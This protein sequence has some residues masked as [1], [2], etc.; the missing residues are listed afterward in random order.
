MILSLFVA[1]ALSPRGLTLPLPA[2]IPS[3]V[4]P[5]SQPLVAAAT[6]QDDDDDG[7]EVESDDEDEDNGATAAYD[8]EAEMPSSAPVDES[9]RYS[10][11]VADHELE[12]RFCRDPASLGS[13][14]V[15]FAD[16]GRVINAVQMPEDDAW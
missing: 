2:S 16:A 8:P 15:G 11:D 9:L 10:L 3:A 6:D 5:E 14:S 12:S 1:L 4:S 13:I 7:D